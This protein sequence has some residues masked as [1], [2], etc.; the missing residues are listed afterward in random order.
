[1]KILLVR[2]RPS[3]QTIGLQHVM[4]VE[5]LELEIL[6][7]LCRSHDE[8]TLADLILE[9]KSIDHFLKIVK[10][11]ILCLTGYITNVTTI[12]S[13]CRT[14]K[15]LD[16]GIKTIVG[17]VHCEV[18]PE[19]F[20]DESI[21]FR[22]VRNASSVFTDL[23]DH[24]EYGKSLP[25]VV[26]SHD[27]NQ[28]IA[29]LPDFDFRVPFPDREITRKYRKKYFYIFHD[30][31]ALIKTSF[32]CPYNCNFCFCTR[33]TGGL[34][35]QRPL[36]EVINELESITEKEIYI[37]DDDFLTDKNRLLSFIE[38]IRERDI[39]KRYLVYGRADFISKHP[40]VIEKLKEIGLRTVIIGFESFSQDELDAYDK[41]ADVRHNEEAMHVLNRLKIDCYATII[42][43]PGWDRADFRHM[44]Q[45]VKEL[46]IH[47]VNLQP[48]TPLPGTGIE[49]PEEDLLISPEEFEKW[50]L[51]H[52]SVRPEKMDTAEFYKEIIS[53]Y[54]SIIYQPRIL[55]KY[56][57]SYSPRMLWKML[58]GSIRVQRQYQEKIKNASINA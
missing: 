5:P 50:D 2:P 17:G 51:A 54:M 30:R 55:L 32:G 3:S 53:A 37:V 44:T 9:K 46:G 25:A 35:R 40:D 7:V 12:K 34:Y 18:C 1:M 39:R 43:S 16:P 56:L 29:G 47:F 13:Y 11:D 20:R 58:S 31:V 10:P 52:V 14:A 57:I 26:L 4:L 45:K 36:D 41:N 28:D 8:V 21:D 33:I 24:I 19:D 27:G 48:L 6:S 38:K 42:V 15:K 49:I 23:L 22:V